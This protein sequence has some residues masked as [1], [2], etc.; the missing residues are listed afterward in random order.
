MWPKFASGREEKPYVSRLLA[1]C[2]LLRRL[3]CLVLENEWENGER[4]G[5]HFFPFLVLNLLT[6]S[7]TGVACGGG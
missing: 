4:T 7:V 5:R 1:G 2:S 3:H 6:V